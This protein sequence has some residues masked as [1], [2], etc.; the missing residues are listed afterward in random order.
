MKLF[1]YRLMMRQICRLRYKLMPETEVRKT[2]PRRHRCQCC[3]PDCRAGKPKE[4]RAGWG[5]VKREQA[6][7][8]PETLQKSAENRKA[9]LLEG[10]Q[11]CRSVSLLQ[12]IAL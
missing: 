10:F 12:K 9:A 8:Q 5:T 3:Q 4:S 1:G 2:S 6:P 7:F 11:V